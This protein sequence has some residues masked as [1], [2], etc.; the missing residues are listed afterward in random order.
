MVKILLLGAGESGKSTVLKQMRLIHGTGFTSFERIQYS[1][2]IWSDTVQSM[3]TMLQQADILGIPLDCNDTSSKLY[4]SKQV[5]L[6]T[7]EWDIM[8]KEFSPEAKR[9][10]SDY[11]VDMGPTVTIQTAMN[12]NHMNH[13]DTEDDDVSGTSNGIGMIASN[14]DNG[15]DDD[16]DDEEV[17]ETTAMLPAPP[18][19]P[20]RLEVAQAIHDLWT[21]DVGIRRV[22]QN[23]H[24]FQMEVNAKHYFEQV[25]DFAN[26][27]YKATDTDILVGRIKTT[28]IFQMQFKVKG[29]PLR[30]FD[31]GGQRSE[32]RKWVHC[33]DNVTA[34][35]FVAAVSEYDEVLFEDDEVNRM[36]ETLD[37]FE[38]ICDTRWFRDTP[39]ILFLNKMDILRTKLKRSLFTDYQPAY[40]G[41]PLNPDQV[42]SYMER[43]F[44]SKNKYPGRPIYVHRTCATDTKSMAFV[45][46][47]V[48]DM[49][50]Q[51]NLTWSGVI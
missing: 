13:M 21:Q 35:L 30:M 39:I 32:R 33:F 3:R 25:F 17:S 8:K 37:L 18:P 23:A 36:Q 4:K 43:I 44:L 40:P 27:Q 29:T 31:V 6:A 51:K 2:V 24:M 49:V 42:C 28:G 14:N 16:E 5:L 48:T 46:A 45:M 11:T 26:P 19:L 12:M 47:A 38:Q 10:L 15:H 22:Y 7:D 9:F 50:F 34:V 20:S 1:K 41:D